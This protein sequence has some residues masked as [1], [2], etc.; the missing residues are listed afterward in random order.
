MTYRNILV[1]VDQSPGAQARI[2]S[3]AAL[4]SRFRCP[5][6]GMFLRSNRIPGNLLS[7][8]ATPMPQDVLD[9][10]LDERMQVIEQASASAKEAFLAGLGAASKMSRWLDVNGD[11]P[12]EPIACARHHDLV[13]VPPRMTPSHGDAGIT[14][15]Q[16]G[17]AS[18]GPV[19]VLKHGGF[20]TDFGRKILV[21]WN[22]SREAVRALHDAWPFLE[23]A[24]EIHFLTV[25][26]GRN[27]ELD[28]LLV[29]QLQDH[30]CPAAQLH[31]DENDEAPV[32]DLIR[33]HVG[34]TG[35][36]MVVMG[37]YGHSRLREFV[38]GGVSRSLLTDPPMPLFLSH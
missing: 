17:M 7:E 24:T 18:G 10:Y 30:L 33:L 11:S 1:H 14:A 34:R 21:A 27:H 35:A 22:D 38:L 20:P 28:A 4:S 23:T 6:T 32:E 5:V 37:L 26:R 16:I 15:A 31:V 19:L 25:G 29:R 3:A 8:A 2:A 12:D 9:G 36:D 13:I